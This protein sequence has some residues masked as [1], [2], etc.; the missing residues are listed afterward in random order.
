MEIEQRSL[1]WFD[2][3]RCYNRQKQGMKFGG[4]V[5]ELVL[6][7]GL[8]VLQQLLHLGQRMHVGREAAFG[9]M[10]HRLIW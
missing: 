4:F 5:G 9:L 10:P 6:H 3:G 7:G 1:S 8:T 2:W